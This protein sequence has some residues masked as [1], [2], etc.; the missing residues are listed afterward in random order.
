MA[1]QHLSKEGKN[2]RSTLIDWLLVYVG[3]PLWSLQYNKNPY[4]YCKESVQKVQ[5]ACI[6]GLYIED[7][8]KYRL[9]WDGK[10][11]SSL[12]YYIGFHDKNRCNLS[13]CDTRNLRR[14]GCPSLEPPSILCPASSK[15]SLG[16]VKPGGKKALDSERMR[17]YLKPRGLGPP[18]SDS[19]LLDHEIFSYFGRFK[20][21][22]KFMSPRVHV[23][24]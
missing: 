8:C 10:Y 23:H 4:S 12:W 18:R 21:N 3:I 24:P 20:I 11:K 6:L 2:A 16:P 5:K 17:C 13:T 14:L 1:E 22:G 7:S 19:G 9:K 15:T